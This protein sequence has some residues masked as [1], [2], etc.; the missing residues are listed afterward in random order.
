MKVKLL[1]MTLACTCVAPMAGNAVEVA[2]DKLEIY[3]KV[4]ASIDYSN[5]DKTSPDDVSG[6]SLSSNSSRIGF[7]GKD[8][9]ENGLGLFW[10]IESTIEFD[11]GSGSLA[12]RNAYAGIKGGFGSLLF[13]HHDTPFKT[14]GSKW[15]VFGDT[16]ADRRAVL[17]ASATVGNKMNQRGKNALMYMNKFGA[18]EMELMYSSDGEDANPGAQDNSDNDMKSVALMYDQGSLFLAVG[19]ES[20]SNLDTDKNVPVATTEAIKGARVAAK[21]KIGAARLGA[22]YESITSDD[23]LHMDRKVMG[24]NAELKA[25]QSTYKAQYLLADDYKDVK[26]SGATMMSV[27]VFNKLDSNTDIYAIYTVTKNDDNAKFQGVD[28]GHGDEVKTEL[29]GSPTALSV[30]LTHKF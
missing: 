12:T 17:G 19:Y 13:G 22:I 20:W 6:I 11:Q 5:N 26:D 4:H 29:G 30:G 15:G 9:L 23:A 8:Q 28:G 2:G 21:Y 18:V 16:V 3:G 10:K 7:K 27:G 24:V 25:G 14:V 1:A